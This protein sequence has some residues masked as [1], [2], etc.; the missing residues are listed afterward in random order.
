MYFVIIL[1]SQHNH[2]LRQRDIKLFSA[3]TRTAFV[4]KSAMRSS[5]SLTLFANRPCHV[6]RSLFPEEFQDWTWVQDPKTNFHYRFCPDC[7]RLGIQEFQYLV[8]QQAIEGGSDKLQMFL[9]CIVEHKLVEEASGD[10]AKRR[11]FN[12]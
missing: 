7:A 4:S 1:L 2:Y 12:T 6:C 5:K 10:Y 3:H 11:K 8:N 9:L